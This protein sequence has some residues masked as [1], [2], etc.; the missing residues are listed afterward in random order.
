MRLGSVKEWLR[1]RDLN[2]RPSGYEYPKGGRA[3]AGLREK[4][5]P[6]YKLKDVAAARL[7]SLKGF[8]ANEANT[9]TKDYQPC[10]KYGKPFAWFRN[11]GKNSLGPLFRNRRD[12]K[13]SLTRF[14]ENVANLFALAIA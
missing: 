11:K 7:L 1:G 9:W 14:E 4:N 8:D 12:R 3:A 2:P 10:D 13:R 6:C 5:N